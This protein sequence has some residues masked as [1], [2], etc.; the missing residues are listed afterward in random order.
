LVAAATSADD[1][2]VSAVGGAARLQSA[3]FTP[4][5]SDGDSDASGPDVAGDGHRVLVQAA[6]GQDATLGE[7]VGTVTGAGRIEVVGGRNAAVDVTGGL[8]VDLLQAGA[9]SATAQA[10]AGDLLVRQGQAAQD[11]SV[12]APAGAA[13][14]TAATAGRSFALSGR[15]VSLG[16]LGGALTGDVTITATQGG[17]TRD[18]LTAGGAITVDVAGV[19]N[20]GRLTGGTV[21]VAAADLNLTD[22]VTARQAQFESRGG[23]LVLGD[24]V[25]G[26]TGGLF[27]SAA[28]FN[29]IQVSDRVDFYAG[30]TS[31]ALAGGDLLVGDLAFSAQRAPAIGLYAGAA[32]DVRILGAFTPTASGGALTIGDEATSSIWRPRSIQLTGSLGRAQVDAAGAVSNVLA[33]N[34]VRLSARQD[35]FMGSPRFV[36]LVSGTPAAQIDLA[37]GQ[38]QGAAPTAS[39]QNRAFLAAGRLSLRA[40]GRIVQQN[41]ASAAGKFAGLYLVN[42]AATPGPVLFVNEP[43]T[44]VDLAGSYLRRS[45]ALA[46]GPPAALG[47]DL[48]LASGVKGATSYRFNGCQFPTGGACTAQD[49]PIFRMDYVNR[50]FSDFYWPLDALKPRYAAPLLTLW[51]PGR[52]DGEKPD[53]IVT[54]AGNEEIWRGS[55]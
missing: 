51:T 14:I 1:V 13:Q 28:E 45:G 4:G 48:S 52:D 50:G 41:T 16:T 18:A 47:T 44:V 15:T 20:L 37:R 25:T 46:S 7:G 31:L 49:A 38:P 5:T 3:T 32:N 24:N 11:L 10:R 26:V 39:E 36:S 53:P 27:I 21:R 23:P 54:G 12:A 35:I 43:S 34:D 8:T 22:T 19:A 30:S 2:I 42:T 6:A 17:F 40:P 9:G 33:F 29:R 55:K